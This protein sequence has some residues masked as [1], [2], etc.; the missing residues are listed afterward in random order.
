MI[1]RDWYGYPLPQAGAWNVLNH[2]IGIS[3]AAGIVVLYTAAK[4][5][6]EFNYRKQSALVF[7][8]PESGVYRIKA[9][10]S[11]KPWGGKGRVAH[12]Y[13]MK[14]DEQRAGENLAFDDRFVRERLTVSGKA[15][16]PGRGFDSPV[17]DSL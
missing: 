16:S 13:I 9:T 2:H 3:E 10:A 15:S 11:S 7:I 4:S 12:L 5:G 14:R 6:K 17:L 1:G 8:V